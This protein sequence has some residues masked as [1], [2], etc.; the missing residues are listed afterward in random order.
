MNIVTVNFLN[1]SKTFS[2]LKVII[3]T[4]VGNKAIAKI[5]HL[6]GFQLFHMIQK[7][8]EKGWRKSGVKFDAV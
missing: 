3:V 4:A 1:F 2:A 8:E 7:L 5:D 6:S